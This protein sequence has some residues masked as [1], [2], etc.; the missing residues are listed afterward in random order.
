MSPLDSLD[1]SRGSHTGSGLELHL[2]LILGGQVPLGGS[3][4]WVWLPYCCVVL[5]SQF[6]AAS[7]WEPPENVRERCWWPTALIYKRG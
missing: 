4:K 3:L 1:S 5:F 7:S 6:A 2:D